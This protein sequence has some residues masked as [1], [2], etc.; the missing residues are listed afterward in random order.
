MRGRDGQ[1]I[2]PGAPAIVAAKDRS[3][4]SV[5]ETGT[6]RVRILIFNG[7]SSAMAL[8]AVTRSRGRI[9]WLALAAVFLASP[10]RAYVLEK[11]S[12]TRDRTVVMQ[13]SLGGPQQLS[14]GF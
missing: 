3:D 1:M 10:V 4:D 7:L 13:L 14:D 6:E 11:A 2:D 5:R 8:A 9:Y 12:W